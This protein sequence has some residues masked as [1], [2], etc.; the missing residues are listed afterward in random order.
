[1]THL[2]DPG[3]VQARLQDIEAD[4]ANRENE[5]EADALAWFRGKREREKARAEEF[6]KAEGTVAERNAIADKATALLH[7][8]DEA[9][10]EAQKSVVKVLDTRAAIGMSLLRSQSRA[11]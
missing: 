1:M 11:A 9:K 8:E 6:L 3:A 5:L 2:S 4:L 7:A 10:Y